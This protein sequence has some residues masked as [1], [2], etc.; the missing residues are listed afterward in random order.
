MLPAAIIGLIVYTI[1]IPTVVGVILYFNREKIMKRDL[2]FGDRFSVLFVVYQRPFYFWELLAYGRRLG[3]VIAKTVTVPIVQCIIGI[4]VLFAALQMQNF[5]KPFSTKNNNR[6]EYISILVPLVILF[7]G[8]LFYSGRL[9]DQTST[10]VISGF[11]LALLIIAV[12]LIVAALYQHG[13]Y[14]YYEKFRKQVS[15]LNYYFYSCFID[16]Y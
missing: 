2:H 3:I 1:G 11:V 6:I 4:I 14:F 5:W 10:H 12:I 13:L 9:P 15:F 7:S 16:F 8:L